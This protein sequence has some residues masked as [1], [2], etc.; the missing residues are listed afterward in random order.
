MSSQ[1]GFNQSL[2]LAF[3]LFFSLLCMPVFAQNNAPAAPSDSNQL[4]TLFSNGLQALFSFI[5]NNF[6]SIVNFFVT[7]IWPA[8][9]SI[10][11]ALFS[12]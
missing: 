10:A 3:T 1:I 9:L 5:S 7:Y 8:I 12:S 6:N 2:V 11:K 4:I